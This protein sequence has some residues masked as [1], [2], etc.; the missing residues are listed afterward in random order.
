MHLINSFYSIAKMTPLHTISLYLKYI[1]AFLCLCYGHCLAPAYAQEA[2]FEVVPSIACNQA[3]IEVIDCTVAAVNIS[4][5]YT[6]EEGFVNRTTHT[7]N[8]PGTYTITQLAQFNIEGSTQAKLTTREIS[9]LP[10]PQPVFQA[11]LCSNRAVSLNITDNQY[12]QY[13]INW[14]DG[15]PLQ[16]VNNTSS[17]LTH[18]YILGGSYSITVNGN[19]VPGNCGG[20]STILVSPINTLSLPKVSQIINQVNASPNG[21]VEIRWEA[22][23]NFV[24]EIYLENTSSPMAL[25]ENTHGATNKVLTGIPTQNQSPCFYFKTSDACGNALQSQALYCSLSL[26]VN[27]QDGQ[28]QIEW[29]AYPSTS[30][31][32]FL[33][34][35]LYRNGQPVQVFT[36]QNNQSFTDTEIN[37]NIEYCYQIIAKLGVSTSEFRASS[38]VACVR[39]FSNQPPQGIRGLNASVEPGNRSIRLFWDMPLNE[40]VREYRIS[41]SGEGFISLTSESEALDT[42][43]KMIRRYCYQ[44]FYINDCEISAPVSG[45]ACPVFLQ[46][47]SP[48]AGRVKLNWTSY[49]NSNNTYQYYVVEK[50]DENLEVY[51]ETTLNSVVNT[52]Y[53]DPDAKTDRQVLRYR[54]RTVIDEDNQL[55]SYSNLVEVQQQFRIF[56]PN[57]FTPNND[58]KNDVFSPKGLFIKNFSM[59]VYTQNGES[60]FSGES[61]EEGWDGKYKSKEMPSGVYVY[62]VEVED[63]T[64]Q[65]FT[66]RG[67]INLIR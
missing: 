27:A 44:I 13:L 42:D 24:Y 37:C 48:E 23:S 22:D 40:S 60:I 56:F 15:S 32:D 26:R 10:T 53:E 61:L 5:K 51:D 47:S 7:Y 21:E 63:F 45:F 54:I 3:E 34:Y 8:D 50:L 33:Q 59:Q 41:R 39:A 2:C 43:V 29:T 55:F 28:N 1:F 57:A 46:A 62:L 9:V 65:K 18:T 38:N 31:T 64:G 36:N 35:I 17:A 58:G 6:E 66:K 25:V 52:D 67:S 11:K 30:A 20:S 12:P 16:T 19:Y 4:Y 14:G 49:Q